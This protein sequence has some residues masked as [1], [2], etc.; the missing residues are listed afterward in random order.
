MTRSARFVLAALVAGLSLLAAAGH[1]LD[2][3][4]PVPP[5]SAMDVGGLTVSLDQFSGKHIVMVFYIGHT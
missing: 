1:A 5:F 2:K 4:Q 3:G